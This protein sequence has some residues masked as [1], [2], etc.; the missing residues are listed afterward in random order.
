MKQTVSCL[1]VYMFQKF[2]ENS[3]IALSI[4]L[5]ADTPTEANT[6]SLTAINTIH[7]N[8]SGHCVFDLNK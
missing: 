1:K 8:A 7:S 2:H 3:R 6:T 5:L 4:S